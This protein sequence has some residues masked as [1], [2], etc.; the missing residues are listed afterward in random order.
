MKLN[1]SSKI[2]FKESTAELKPALGDICAFANGGEG[3]LY[4]GIA[5]DG[6]VRIPWY[7]LMRL[8]RL[9]RSMRKLVP[10]LW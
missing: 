10:I 5:D 9:T 1:E 2:E 8:K 6:E 3:V 7:S 4:F